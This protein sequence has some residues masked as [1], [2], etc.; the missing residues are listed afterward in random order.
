MNDK[1]FVSC[2]MATYG[3][4]SFVERALACFLMQDYPERELIILNTHAVPLRLDYRSTFEYPLTSSAKIFIVNEPCHS[5]LG[6]QRNR[7]LSL[8]QG[9]L[10]RSWDD[11]DIYLPWSISQGVRGILDNPGRAAWKP[12]QSWYSAGAGIAPELVENTLEPS[13]TFR[14]DIARKYRYFA[15]A[16]GDEHVGLIGGINLHEGGFVYGDVGVSTGFCCVY[17]AGTA[18]HVS[19]T[20]GEKTS[21]TERAARWRAQQTDVSREPLRPNWKAAEEWYSLLRK[22]GSVPP[23]G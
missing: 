16:S 8:A 19:G 10:V 13:I 9:D 20:L 15:N 22:H 18:P 7:L 14:A 2:L 4:H 6:D 21:A 12:K 5:T 3:R 23:Q 11:D 17:G 1:P